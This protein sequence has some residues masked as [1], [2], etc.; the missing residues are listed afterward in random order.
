MSGIPWRRLAR[1]SALAAAITA[2]AGCTSSEPS[3]SPTA[4]LEA[5]ASPG[6]VATPAPEGLDEVFATLRTSIA[7]GA[8][9]GHPHEGDWGDGPLT[10]KVFDEVAAAGF[11]AVR[12]P[13][14]FSGYQETTAPYTID[15]EF[16]DRVEWAVDGLTSRGLTVII[17]NFF[18]VGAGGTPDTELLFTNPSSRHDRFLAIWEQLAPLFADRDGRVVFEILNEP[19]DALDAV[20][21][22]YQQE[23][24]DVI[25][26]TNPT[27][28]VILTGPSWSDASRLDDI[29]LPDDPNIIVTFHHYFPMTFTHQG[30]TFIEP[31]FPTGVEWPGDNLTL[32]YPWSDGSWNADRMWTPEGVTVAYTGPWGALAFSNVAGIAGAVSV[33]FT[34]DADVEVAVHCAGAHSGA[35]GSTVVTAHAGLPTTVA[36]SACSGGELSPSQRLTSFWIQN[37]GGSPAS[38]TVTDARIT[39]ASGD[40]ALLVDPVTQVEGPVLAAAAYGREHDVPVFMGEFGANDLAPMDSR[41]RWTEA[42]RT[43]AV[44]NGVATS[45][46]GFIGNFGLFHPTTGTFDEALLAAVTAEP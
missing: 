5:S 30:V 14:R 29:A 16:L 15:P 33:S 17:T 37:T 36:V 46:W 12:L 35:N 11:T 22:G 41:V 24:L 28:P 19:H 26:E 39:T 38:F 27:R 18:S 6:V 4:T 32:A 43:C 34:T 45:Y 25:R 13:V 40:V 31:R 8:L 20:W 2:I 21:N 10:D 42:V 1:A 7:L 44:E 3:A 23:A 9:A